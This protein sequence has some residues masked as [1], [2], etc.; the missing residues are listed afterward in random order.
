M[1]LVAATRDI[2]MF[3]YNFSLILLKIEV[4][5]HKHMNI[6]VFDKGLAYMGKF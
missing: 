3:C 4:Y 5:T 1:L 2:T 6:L